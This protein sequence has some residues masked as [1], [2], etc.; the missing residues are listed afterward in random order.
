MAHGKPGI[1][2]RRDH[3]RGR[4]RGDLGDRTRGF[5]VLGHEAGKDAAAL[6][7]SRG[8]GASEIASS[9]RQE[10][11][12]RKLVQCGGDLKGRLQRRLILAELGQRL[13]HIHIFE[14]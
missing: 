14:A 3:I 8:P 7:P 10:I 4:C 6:K 9:D 13:G 5:V 2:G 1:L 12:Q 11:E